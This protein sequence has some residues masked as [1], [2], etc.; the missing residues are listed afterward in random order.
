M[1]LARRIDTLDQTNC[2]S[3]KATQPANAIPE[4]FVSSCRALDRIS[5]LAPNA[6]PRAM[7]PAAGTVVTEMK[8]P[9]KPPDRAEVSDRTPAV[10]AMTATMKDHLS[11]L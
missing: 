6:I 5:S 1:A 4:I 8:T 10:P 11:G 9:A 7:L 2:C 3:A